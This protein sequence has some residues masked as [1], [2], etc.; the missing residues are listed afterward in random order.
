MKSTL[1]C[2]VI[3]LVA[4]VPANARTVEL[5]IYPAKI[6][7]PAQKY[8]LLPKADE[9]S[10]GDA[11]PLYEKAI[12]SLPSDLQMK[13]IQQWLKTPLDTLP[14]KQVQSILQQFEPALVLLEEAAKYKMCYWPYMDDDLLSENL[15]KHRRLIFILTLKIRFQIAQGLYD[16]AICT[17]QAGFTMA[18]NLEK[19]FSLL[20]GLVGIGIAA[21]IS[22]QLEQFVQRPDSPDLYQ[23][24]QDLPLPFI[25]LSKLVESEYPNIRDKVHLLM[26]RLDRHVAALKCI[27]ALRL[28][29]AAHDGKFPNAL[30]DIT[31]VSVTIDPVTRKPFIY[32]RAGS[33]ALLEALPMEGA[34]DKDIIRYEISLK[35]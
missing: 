31:E 23:A 22:R 1:I 17:A 9:Q 27:E 29:A 11:A 25:D 3:L 12:Q 30:A 19:D 6:P 33:K 10:N 35:E 4:A 16:D 8:Q 20:R 18:K 14:G 7:K 34:T 5:T 2:L 24:L 26:N 21:Q 32:Q 15:S 13:E 28:Y